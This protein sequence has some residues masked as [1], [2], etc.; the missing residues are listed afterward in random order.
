MPCIFVVLICIYL[1]QNSHILSISCLS[2][3]FKKYILLFV[4]RIKEVHSKLGY[5]KRVMI[6]KKVS[7]KEMYF[8]LKGNVSPIKSKFRQIIQNVIIS[9]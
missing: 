3:V 2:F 6:H 1:S 8:R 4:H 9:I 7:L 5:I